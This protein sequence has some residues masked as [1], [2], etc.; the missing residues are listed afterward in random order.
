MK[1]RKDGVSRPGKFIRFAEKAAL[2]ARIGNA[3]AIPKDAE[4][5]K[6]ARIKSG[7]YIKKD[8]T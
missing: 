6:D 7:K 2:R 5:A 4:K 1:R 8:E 3:W